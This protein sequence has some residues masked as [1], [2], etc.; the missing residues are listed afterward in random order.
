MNRIISKGWRDS[1]SL[2][3][4]N[5]QC[6]GS[7]SPRERPCVNYEV[8]LQTR[9]SRASFPNSVVFPGG[10]DE[11]ADTSPDWLD[12]LRSFGYSNTDFDALHHAG[13]P[14]TPI[15]QPDPV[16]RLVTNIYKLSL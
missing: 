1:A 13:D 15:F 8:L 16:K 7:L 2:I 4:L 10:V 9:T 3:V 5:K 12:L 11:P 6:R 14:V